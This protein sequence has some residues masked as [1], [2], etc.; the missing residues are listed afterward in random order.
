MTGTVA[1]R[2][3]ALVPATGSDQRRR[4][5]RR[6]R[7]PVLIP[8]DRARSA[9]RSQTA[10]GTH[11]LACLNRT[12]SLIHASSY[13]LFCLCLFFPFPLRT[14]F[15]VICFVAW[16]WVLVVL[17]LCSPISPLR[18]LSGC[19]RKQSPKA[20]PRAKAKAKANSQWQPPRQHPLSLALV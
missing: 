6:S 5:T 20:K 2:L 10:I 19:R 13:L 7:S 3:P 18:L 12:H 9:A 17:T 11:H 8:V 1:W 14:N 15:F 4:A 16:S